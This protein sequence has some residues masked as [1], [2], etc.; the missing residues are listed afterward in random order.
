MVITFLAMLEMCKLKLIRV[1]Q[2]EGDGR[3]PD[4]PKGEALE[5]LQL[6]HR[7]STRVSTGKDGR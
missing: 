2:D 6:P 4:S 1:F 7:R 3:H 5:Q